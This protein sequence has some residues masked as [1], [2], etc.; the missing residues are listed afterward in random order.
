VARP[1]RLVIFGL[2]GIDKEWPLLRP[3]NEHLLVP[4]GFSMEGLDRRVAEGTEDGVDAR[5]IARTLRLEPLKNVLID[6]Q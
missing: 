4:N 2:D 5:L 6:P 1:C 3:N